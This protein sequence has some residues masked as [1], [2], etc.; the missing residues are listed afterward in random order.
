MS[1]ITPEIQGVTRADYKTRFKKGDPRINRK[2]RPKGQSWRDLLKWAGDIPCS[3]ALAYV[4]ASRKADRSVVK[5][6]GDMPLR[7]TVAIAVFIQAVAFPDA[8]LLGTIMDREDG[9]TKLSPY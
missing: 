3:Q 1:N 2:G 5:L 7:E 4:P 8:S 9:K 6:C